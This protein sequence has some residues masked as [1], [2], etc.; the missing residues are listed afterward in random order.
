V[1]HAA[2]GRTCA[3]AYTWMR[4]CMCACKPIRAF[5]CAH[6][7]ICTLWSHT[8]TCHT[9]WRVIRGDVSHGDVSHGES[10]GTGGL[11]T[12]I[13]INIVYHE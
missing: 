3:H 12:W 8:V 1:S 4:A 13:L 11:E 5:T 2:A 7:S 6:P 10:G 9:R